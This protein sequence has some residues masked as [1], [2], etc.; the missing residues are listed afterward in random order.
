[1]STPNRLLLIAIGIICLVTLFLYLRQEPTPKKR[2]TIG[3]TTFEIEIPQTPAQ[4]ALGLG[5]REE[6]GEKEGMLFQFAFPARHPFWMKGML[7]DLDFVFV[8]NDEVIETAENIPFP[9][10]GERPAHVISS[11]LFT[12]VL[13]LRAGSI[14]KYGLA[15]GD[16]VHFEK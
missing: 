12:S 7:F 2:L 9:Q 15:V 10:P 13:E 16:T 8:R 4:K 6:I 3:T 14:K 11:R 1:M 5:G